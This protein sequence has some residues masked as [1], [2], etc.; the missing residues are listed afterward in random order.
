MVLVLVMYGNERADMALLSVLRSP[1]WQSC[2]IGYESGAVDGMGGYS[3][4]GEIGMVVWLGFGCSI[5]K[6]TGVRSV[7]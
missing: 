5:Y 1:F 6:T 7:G 3:L 2:V 4:C